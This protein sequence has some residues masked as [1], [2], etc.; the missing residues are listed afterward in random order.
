M[1]A[2]TGT[3]SYNPIA[4]VYIT[5]ALKVLGVL[6][7]GVGATATQI[8]DSLPAVE[9]YVKGLSKYG[10]SLWKVKTQSIT[11]TDACSYVPPIKIMRITDAVFRDSDGEDTILIPLT[12]EEYWNLSDKDQTSQPSQ[13]YYDPQINQA[14]STV[15][16]WPCP[17]SNNYGNG[18]TIELVGIILFEDVGDGGDSID[19]PQEWIETITYGIATRLAP[20]FGYPVQER[21]LL[22]KEYGDMFMSSLDFDTEQE[23]IYLQPDKS[24]AT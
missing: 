17:D 24:K 22:L 16:V 13:F 10:L 18:E 6:E 19:V 2:T 3:Y 4:S 21:N 23:S 12:R 5:E 7:E 1:A 11:L 9:A 8:T 14:T 20:A 15:Y